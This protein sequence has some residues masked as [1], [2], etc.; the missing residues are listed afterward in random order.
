MNTIDYDCFGHCVF[1]HK[2]MIITQIID[3]VPMKRFSIEYDETEYL[4]DNG[5]KMRVAICK[6][7]KA[8]LTEK[9]TP[10]IMECVKRGWKKEL[11]QLSWSEEKKND[12]IERYDKLNIVSKPIKEIIVDTFEDKIKEVKK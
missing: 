3:N 11:T 7:C 10:E 9:D 8:K 1:C 2:D 12:Y 5:S 6:P 4:L